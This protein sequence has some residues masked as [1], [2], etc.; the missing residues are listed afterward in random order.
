VCNEMDKA[1]HYFLS[2]EPNG[3]HLRNTKATPRFYHVAML[4]EL[5]AAAGVKIS[6]QNMEGV[7]AGAPLRVVKG[8]NDPAVRDMTEESNI[9][10]E[11]SD[12]GVTIKADAIGSLEALAFEA[13]AAGMPIRKY[14]VGEITRRDIVETAAYGDTQ[15]KVILGFNVSMSKDAEAEAANHEIRI[16]SDPVVYKIIEDYKEWL[17]ESKKR[18][19]SDKRSEFP[20]P[21]KLRILPGCIFRASKPAIVG[22]RVLAGRIKANQRLLGADGRDAGKIRSIHSGE[23]TLKE[24]AQGE[25]VAISLEG[26]TAGRQINEED[27]IYV[28]LLES[29]VK[30]LSTSIGLNEDE[31]MALSETIT[32]KRKEE[33]FWGM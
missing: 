25:E 3:Y 18:S 7:I 13:K 30:E 32:I 16:F 29:T 24:A 8:P 2:K 20:F 33:P 5:H 17:E 19:E 1:Q 15:N 12:E 9:K 4:K 23:D 21:A 26:V 28:D 22:V 6:C 27:V 31:K 14:G 10:V 11:L